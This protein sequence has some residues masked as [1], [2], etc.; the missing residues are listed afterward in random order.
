MKRVAMVKSIIIRTSVLL[1]AFAMLWGIYHITATA[2]GIYVD[3][4]YA[5]SDGDVNFPQNSQNKGVIQG[6][7][8]ANI[9]SV[10]SA[11]ESQGAPMEV[12]MPLGEQLKAM[13]N[14][15]ADAKGVILESRLQKLRANTLAASALNISAGDLV[16]KA[17]GDYTQTDNLN[18][19]VSGNSPKEEFIVSGTTDKYNMTVEEGAKSVITLQHV[20]CHLSTANQKSSIYIKRGAKVALILE[21]SKAN[22]AG[23]TSLTGS[24]SMP[25]I[26]L[27]E[28]ASLRLEGDGGLSVY[29]GGG[30]FAMGGTTT[31]IPGGVLWVGGKVDLKGYSNMTQGALNVKLSSA[32]DTKR[33]MQGSLFEAA[34][35]NI[36]VKAEN[37]DSRIEKYVMELKT[38]TLSFATSTTTIGGNYVSFIAADKN[39]QVTGGE[40]LADAAN[41][42]FHS[43]NLTGA[44]NTMASLKN[45]KPQ[46]IEYRVTLDANEGTCANGQS[47]DYLENVGYGETISKPTQDPTRNNHEFADWHKTKD[48]FE[49]GDKWKFGPAPGGDAVVRD[50]VIL[51]A[52]WKPK[53]CTVLFKNGQQTVKKLT[54]KAF[55]DTIGQNESP[56]LT[57][58]G[59]TLAGW[60]KEDGSKWVFGAA[61]TK[62]MKES[63]VLQANWLK[64]CKI[65]FDANVKG[66]EVLN[67]PDPN[68]MTVSATM[69][70]P[71]VNTPTRADYQFRA[72]YT[73]AACTKKWDMDVDTVK[74]DMKLYAGW[75]ANQTRVAFHV[76][77]AEG[78]TVTPAQATVD[79]GNSIPKPVATKPKR[80]DFPTEYG[81]EGWYTDPGLKN[82]WDFS[83]ELEDSDGLFDLYVKWHQVTCWAV[84]QP[85]STE[86]QPQ[87]E[88]TLS[89]N[90]NNSLKT[91]IDLEDKLNN[92]F[93]RPGYEV[94]SWVTPSGKVWDMDTPLT[95]DIT[96][97]AQWSPQIF[98]VKFETP[99][100][101]PALSADEQRLQAAYGTMLTKP[102][103]PGDGSPWPGRT[104]QGWFT[105]A[106]GA[107][108]KWKFSD[109]PG[110]NKVETDI[111]LY[112][113]WTENEYTVQFE[114]YKGDDSPVPPLT[115]VKYGE[116]IAEPGEPSRPHYSFTGWADEK[117][118]IWDFKKDKVLK[119]MVLYAQ[120][121]GE[122]VKVT[123]NI[124]YEPEHTDSGKTVQ[125]NLS[126]VRY[127]DYLTKTQVEDQNVEATKERPG[128]TLNGWFTQPECRPEQAWNFADS[129]VD[130]VGD[131]LSLYAYWTWDEYTVQF[132]TFSGDNSIPSQEGLRY[133]DKIIRPEPDPLRAH[134]TFGAWHY[135]TDSSNKKISNFAADPD[136]KNIWD[137]ATQTVVGDTRLY[138]SWI[139]DVYTLTFETNGGTSLDPVDVPYG[140]YVSEK[141]L[142]TKKEGF[143]LSGW[144]KD[145]EFTEP[146][147]PM[148][149]YVDQNMTLYAKWGLKA[150]TVRFHFRE[151]KD[152]KEETVDTYTNVYYEGDYLTKPEKTL[153]HKI[154]SSWYKDEAYKEKWVFGRDKLKEDI[155]LYA[156]WSDTKY[157]VHFETSGGTQIGDKTMIWGEQPVKPP[158]PQ[159]KGHTFTG[160]FKN[161][162]LTIPWNFEEDFV[163]GNTDIYA[164]WSAD[165]YTVTFDG[166]G[167]SPVPEP[168]ILPYG[169]LIE[170]P[171]TPTKDGFGF[172]GWTVGDKG[173]PWNFATNTVEGDTSLKVRWKDPNVSD[174]NQDKNNITTAA[175]RSNGSNQN[176]QGGQR[177]GQAGQNNGQG[178]ATQALNDAAQ[179][180]KKVLTGDQSSLTYTITAIILAAATIIGVLYK[181][182]K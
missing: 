70:I 23:I 26:M 48:S 148:T 62:I 31:T 111:T 106:D 80:A 18:N 10:D 74:K 154:L 101:A 170:E 123:L 153:P 134:Y 40:L 87:Q 169:S 119:N 85:N 51:Y 141:H 151:S 47:R 21:N 168:R 25:A 17:G 9:L 38:G 60:L 112:A 160:W 182:F 105:K 68:P 135:E 158:D 107:G 143:L 97:K 59:S 130:P 1:M 126:G 133:G 139:P 32:A 157:T 27:E 104:F 167:G 155:D 174:A 78:E 121:E 56:S 99:A 136:N 30:A 159:K 19:E 67:M 76:N 125:V 91:H 64:D 58:T 43:Y 108:E 33:I 50:G 5:E 71:L 20:S 63:T 181:K 83:K 114:T 173:A 142:Q 61:G 44:G 98:T 69:K 16:F 92:M 28:G 94:N 177:N 86:A 73:D 72:W 109:E 132:V 100:D 29:G 149:E 66:E 161:A 164:G 90:Y 57:N 46:R 140:T 36:F 127:G 145:P 37:R 180:L 166:N 96:L 8:G 95:G 175:D 42:S 79:F 81:V 178:S 115:G 39:A 55:E 102:T 156:Y 88:Q 22:P 4:S 179:T 113:H 163:A 12:P 53:D 128:Y 124:K 117:G 129:K 146:F 11:V 116:I 162:E 49:T 52:S 171:E 103:Y 75:G 131:E 13:A 82:R 24:P 138:A 118:K 35:G 34:T 89:V 6:A 120:W 2:V 15:K 14:G 144:Y 152:S 176:G 54:G 172:D 122:P 77:G 7:D 147:S 84:F 65:T 137:F 110:A 93:T 41:K 3:E 165:L 45:L 150:C